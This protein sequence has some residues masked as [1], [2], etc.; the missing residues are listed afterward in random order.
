MLSKITW[1]PGDGG[2]VFHQPYS[3]VPRSVPSTHAPAKVNTVG[4]VPAAA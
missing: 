4:P 1:Y 2:A 3:R